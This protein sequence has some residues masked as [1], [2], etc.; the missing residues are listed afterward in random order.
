MKSENAKRNAV[1]ENDPAIRNPFGVMD[2]PNPNDDDVTQFARNTAP[3][4][5]PPMKM[6]RLGALALRA[7]SAVRSKASGR[8]AGTA[9]PSFAPAFADRRPGNPQG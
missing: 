2:V 9:R 6:Q 8:A 4:N 7:T 1:S 3:E 5:P